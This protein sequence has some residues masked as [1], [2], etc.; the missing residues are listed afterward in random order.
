MKW[1]DFWLL[2]K[3]SKIRYVCCAGNV[4]LHTHTYFYNNDLII[5]TSLVLKAQSHCEKFTCRRTTGPVRPRI[6]E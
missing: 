5:M 1:C 3:I 4:F 2:F 6:Y